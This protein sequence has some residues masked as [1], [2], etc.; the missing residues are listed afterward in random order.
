VSMVGRTGYLVQGAASQSV[1]VLTD[2]VADGESNRKGVSLDFGG[3]EFAI[4]IES[5][6]AA[7]ATRP[8]GIEYQ[9]GASADTNTFN[10][11]TATGASGL[12]QQ[13]I[14]MNYWRH[15]STDSLTPAT[16]EV[17]EF[18]DDGVL[19]PLDVALEEPSVNV[20][21][22]RPGIADIS[23]TCI[24]T[25]TLDDVLDGGSQTES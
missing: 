12:K 5:E 7:G 25:A 16:L 21:N 6:L 9:W 23:V 14:F 3:G 10:E 4:E 2:A 24:E 13:Q 11:T 8:D 15:G 18:R 20:I 19:E 22:S 17:G 1:S